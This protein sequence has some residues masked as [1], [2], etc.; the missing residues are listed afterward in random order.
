MRS[1]DGATTL[2]QQENACPVLAKRELTPAT[3]TPHHGL[4]TDSRGSLYFVDAFNYRIQEFAVA[5]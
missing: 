4:A 1:A 5:H 3:S 2:P